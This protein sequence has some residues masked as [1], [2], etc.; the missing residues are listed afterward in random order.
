MA[1]FHDANLQMLPLVPSWS[2]C[3][4][5]MVPPDLCLP[6]YKINTEFWR[7]K[8]TFPGAP[9]LRRPWDSWSRGP[10]LE[11]HVGYKCY[12]KKKNF[13]QTK[14]ELFLNWNTII[15]IH[16]KE[17]KFTHQKNVYETD[18][19]QAKKHGNFWKIPP[20]GIVANIKICGGMF[21]KLLLSIFSGNWG[22]QM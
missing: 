20:K 8:W 12:F 13:K 17:S 1:V 11:P 21:R 9:S 2:S 6:I 4:V 18:N 5:R 15:P 14:N 10:E 3:P 22:S 19:R 16:R 7:S